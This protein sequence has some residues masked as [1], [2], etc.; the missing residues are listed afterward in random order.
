MEYARTR[1]VPVKDKMAEWAD[2]INA[3]CRKK[4]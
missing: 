4:K 1:F 3:P 2:K